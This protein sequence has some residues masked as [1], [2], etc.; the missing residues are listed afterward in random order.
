MGEVNFFLEDIKFVLRHKPQIKSWLNKIAKRE[1]ARILSI[2][3]IFCSDDYL[4]KMNVQY[5]KHRTLTDIIT[6][7]HSESQL[8]LE[9]D[10]FI[11]IDRV[12]ENAT[13][14]GE[15]FSNELSRVIVH[16]LLHL[17]GFKDKTKQQKA[18]M[19]LKEEESL[20]SLKVPRG[21]GK[22]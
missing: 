9:A 12:K 1:G 22:G 2:N 13:N 10:I 16:G 14:R 18:L 6:F 11:S 20:L 7:D 5:L 8:T 4:Y 17:V 21:T 19:R 15:S 3:Y